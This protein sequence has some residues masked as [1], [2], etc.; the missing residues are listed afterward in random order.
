MTADRRSADEPQPVAASLPRN[1]LGPSDL[2]ID[3]PVRARLADHQAWVV[4]YADATGQVT[5]RAIIP[6]E[7]QGTIIAPELFNAEMVLAWCT[8]RRELRH[9]R[10]D[11][12]VSI[13]GEADGSEI[14]AREWLE[15]LMKGARFVDDRD[16]TPPWWNGR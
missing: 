10:P 4:E 16:V 5:V 6:I 8:L 2:D 11:R 13:E 3:R 9:F 1:F 7:V 12:F 14:D 15:G